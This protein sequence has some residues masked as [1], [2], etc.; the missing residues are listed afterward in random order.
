MRIIISSSGF[1]D[2]EAGVE[3]LCPEQPIFH[4]QSHED[5][6]VL[7]KD[8]FNSPSYRD[9]AA[10][11]LSGAVQIPS[12]TYDEMEKVGTDPRWNIF[13][14]FAKYLRDTFPAL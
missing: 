4:P 3:D 7:S 11:R 2:D 1:Q 5:I 6:T 13:Y 10:Q 12:V 8:L 14:S 9:L